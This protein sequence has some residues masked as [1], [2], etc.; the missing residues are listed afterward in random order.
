MAYKFIGYSTVDIE[1]GSVTLTDVNLAI[2]D[3]YNHFYTR[4]GER[5]GEPDFGSIIPLMVFEQLDEISVF[6][7][8][9]DV[10]N[11]INS[12][13]RWEFINLKTEIGQNSVACIVEI[14]YVP[15]TQVETLY[16]NY[17]A[18]ES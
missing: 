10:R 13:P 3:L 5:L 17:T 7:I 18:E 8:E 9:Q 11:I 14:R 1:F 6:E 16:L 15:T 4:R 12:D 2:R